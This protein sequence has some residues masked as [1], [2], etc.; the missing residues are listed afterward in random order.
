MIAN[1]LDRTW[2][3]GI[4]RC[5]QIAISISKTQNPIRLLSPGIENSSGQCNQRYCPSFCCPQQE[6]ILKMLIASQPAFWRLPLWDLRGW[7]TYIA[8]RFALEYHPR[9]C[10]NPWQHAG[11]QANYTSTRSV[12]LHFWTFCAV[13][14]LYS[15]RWLSFWRVL[16]QSV[17]SKKPR[18]RPSGYRLV[19]KLNG[20]M[21]NHSYCD[22]GYWL[23]VRH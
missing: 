23:T 10:D 17:F 4:G 13:C 8:L 18:Q 3:Y 20:V 22:W 5:I 7:E 16:S 21:H 9:S 11:Q 12:Q 15:R 14:A 2:N 6:H 1:K 19:L